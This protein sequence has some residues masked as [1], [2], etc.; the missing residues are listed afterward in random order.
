MRLGFDDSSFGLT[1]VVV[2][3][4]RKNIRESVIWWTVNQM[5]KD[6]VIGAARKGP[7]KTTCA[8]NRR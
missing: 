8:D 4:P 1:N 5:E 7:K 3:F 2:T 6:A